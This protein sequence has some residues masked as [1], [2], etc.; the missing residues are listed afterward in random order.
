M[1]EHFT[2]FIVLEIQTQ[3]MTIKVFKAYIIEKS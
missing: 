1:T 3:F 2:L